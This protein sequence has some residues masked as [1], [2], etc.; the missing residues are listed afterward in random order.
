MD[1][2][3]IKAVV[4]WKRPSNVLEI[5]SF[6]GLAGYYRRF[7]EEFSKIAGPLTQL[8]KKGMKFVWTE[9]CEKA[10]LLLKEKLTT[11]LVLTLPINERPY[12]VFTDASH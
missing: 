11:T 4:D 5:R 6:L 12:V 10:F 9:Q 3:K 7:V 8:T 2:A 1:P